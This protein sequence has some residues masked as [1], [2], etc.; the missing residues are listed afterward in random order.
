MSQS[1]VLNTN[2]QE[3]A[4]NIFSL[5]IHKAI[6]IKAIQNL[7]FK[8]NVSAW[9]IRNSGYTDPILEE[10]YSNTMLEII[11]SINNNLCTLDND[12]LIFFDEDEN[13]NSETFLNIYRSISKYL[14][15]QRQKKSKWLCIEEMD[16]NGESTI[17]SI[18]DKLALS[19]RSNMDTIEE[20]DV[21]K[22]VRSALKESDSN[23]LT[24]L[25]EG[26]SYREIATKR[27]VT[28]KAVECAVNRIRKAFPKKEIKRISETFTKYIDN[29]KH[30]YFD[31]SAKHN[32]VLTE[33]V[34]NAYNA[35]TS[36]H[37]DFIAQCHN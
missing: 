5:G 19:T 18:N 7:S 34:Q 24:D 31:F 37:N 2:Q 16:E 22:Q 21:I 13:G 6:T 23:I 26:L 27:N 14:Y 12:K 8:G 17:Y 29:A 30:N 25:L 20:M 10:L 36:L 3:V 9:N 1:I 11:E 35:Y 32:E 33:N 28:K 4:S 15:N